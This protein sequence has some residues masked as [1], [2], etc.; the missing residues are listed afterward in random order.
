MKVENRKSAMC[1]DD[2]S[3]GQIRPGV[4]AP[5]GLEGRGMAEIVPKDHPKKAGACGRQRPLFE[6]SQSVFV[7]L[8]N[9]D[10]CTISEGSTAKSDAAF[11]S[12]QTALKAGVWLKLSPR[13]IPRRL[14]CVA[15]EGHRL[16]HQKTVRRRHVKKKKLQFRLFKRL[17]MMW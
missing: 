5:D 15:A 9:R 1:A 17:K 2:P 16:S 12:L 4:R 13:L 8:K 10:P 11:L 3:D 6:P 14:G 7:E